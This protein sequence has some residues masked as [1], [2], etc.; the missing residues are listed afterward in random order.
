MEIYTERFNSVARVIFAGYS[1]VFL[2][3]GDSAL[4]FVSNEAVLR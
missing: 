3:I 2:E 4:L 1:L